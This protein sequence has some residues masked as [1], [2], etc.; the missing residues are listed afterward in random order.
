MQ[1]FIIKTEVRFF[2]KRIIIKYTSKFPPEIL[3]LN[4]IGNWQSN[5][6][7]IRYLKKDKRFGYYWINDEIEAEVHVFDFGNGGMVKDLENNTV[8][9]KSVARFRRI[10]N[11]WHINKKNK[12][13]RFAVYDRL[14]KEGENLHFLQRCANL[15]GDKV[16]EF[17][18]GQLTV[19]D[20]R[21]I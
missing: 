18:D 5:W 17:E 15:E 4:K 10:S 14:D 1:K 20:M 7:K 8:M 2:E 13:V 9:F 3:D 11:K 6:K 21:F 16:F 19:K 12:Q